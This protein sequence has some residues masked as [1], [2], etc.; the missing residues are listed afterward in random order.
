MP[1]LVLTAVT[2]GVLLIPPLNA[3]MGQIRIGL[4]FPAVETGFGVR[5]AAVARY[6]PIT[7]FT[8]PGMMLLITSV[9]VWL[10]YNA[11]GYYRRLGG[12]SPDGEHLVCTA[13]RRRAGFG[14]CDRVPGDE[15]YSGS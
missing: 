12:A 9:V 2:L 14:P 1:Y 8:H 7:V 11:G 10:V 15:P 5:N 3:M 4:P 13:D 6:A